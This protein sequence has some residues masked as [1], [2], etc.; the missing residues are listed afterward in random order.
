VGVDLREVAG[1]EA[2]GKGRTTWGG[3]LL[4]Y[5]RNSNQLN[6]GPWLIN[7]MEE[8]LSKQSTHSIVG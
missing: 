2:G 1:F 5:Q 4:N 7:S 6:V 8:K 3:A